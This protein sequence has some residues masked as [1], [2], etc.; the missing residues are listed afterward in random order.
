MTAGDWYINGGGVQTKITKLEFTAPKCAE[1]SFDALANSDICSGDPYVAL[2]GTGTV[3]DGGTITYKWYAEGADESD[4]AA[5]LGTEATYTPSADGKYY[6]IATNSLSGYSD[7]VKK[8]DLVSVTHFASA[9]ITTAPENVR[10]DAGQNATLTVVASGKNLSYEWFTCDDEMGTNPAAII[11]A[12]TNASLAVTVTAGMNQY[13]KVVVYSDC[14]NASAIALVEEWHELPQVPVSATTTWDWQYAATTTIAP[15]KDVEILMANIKDGVKKMTND[16]TFNSQA[17]LFQGQEAY[18]VENSRAFAKGGHIK[19]T[20]TVPGMVTVEFS[21]NGNN[22]R[23]LKIN[24]AISPESSSSKTDV[25]TFSAIVPAGEVMLEGVNGDGTGNDRYI[26]ISKIIFDTNPDLADADYTRDVTE[27]R[28]GTICLPNGGVMVGAE[29]FEIAYYGATSE[30]IFF[31]NIPSGEMEAGIPYIFLPKA[32]ATQL[33][34]FYT[35]EANASAGSKN[36]LI[37]S[38]AQVPITP[39]DDNYILLNNQYCEVVSTEGA[40]YVGA[41]RAYIKLSAITPT[42]PALAPGR[43]RISMGVQSQNAAT[44]MDEL[45]ASDTPVKML[46]DG[47]LFILRGEKMYN[48]NGQLVKLRKTTPNPSLKRRGTGED[49]E[50]NYAESTTLYDSKDC[51]DVPVLRNRC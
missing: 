9:A 8:S 1:P 24:D 23:K 16:E 11:P 43:R 30:K 3:T 19:F 35:D 44:G 21:D 32:G 31:D 18:I 47:Q 38:Y 39:D 48:A 33:G 12:Q 13:Y 42:E 27:G 37:G 10:M 26:R 49:K 28:F 46:I 20:T 17:L 4:P 25:K 15:E 36:G 6:V 41:N 45:N 50:R 2:D 7:N 29:L 51:L 14:G 5:V 22:N 34:V 40:V